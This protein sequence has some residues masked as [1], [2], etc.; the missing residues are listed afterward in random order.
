MLGVQVLH[1]S[2]QLVEPMPQGQSAGCRLRGLAGNAVGTFPSGDRQHL[3]DVAHAGSI[4]SDVFSDAGAPSGRPQSGVLP[5]RT[6]GSRFLWLHRIAQSVY[7]T[8]PCMIPLLNNP[9]LGLLRTWATELHTIRLFCRLARA[10]RPCFPHASLQQRLSRLV[11]IAQPNPSG[12]NK[13][14]DP[15]CRCSNETPTPNN[16]CILARQRGGGCY[17]RSTTRPEAFFQRAWLLR[18]GIRLRGFGTLLA[19]FHR[20]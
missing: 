13:P 16:A 8:K 17:M 5:T 15:S 4:K 10:T 7:K 6:P 3:T 18:P 12:R 14:A 11:P 2:H 19:R 1:T 20:T 9:P